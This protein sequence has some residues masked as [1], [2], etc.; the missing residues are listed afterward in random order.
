ML[1]KRQTCIRPMLTYLLYQ[2]ALTTM[3]RIGSRAHP[4]TVVNY[5]A[6]VV[7]LASLTAVVVEQ[8]K[9]PTSFSVWMYMIVVGIFGG[10]MVGR[11]CI[12]KDND[13]EC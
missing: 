5:F 11:Q 9:W 3:R 8:T 6:W 2:I 10:L 7:F 1:W 12:T 4:L 13:M